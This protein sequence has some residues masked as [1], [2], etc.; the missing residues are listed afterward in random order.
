LTNSTL[1]PLTPGDWYLAVSNASSGPVAYSVKATE[2]TVTGLPIGFSNINFISN[3]LCLTW[4]SLVGA[5]YFVEGKPSLTGT[6]WTVISPS[7]LATTSS[8]SYCV[9]LPST[10]N[11]FRVQEGL[12]LTGNSLIVPAPVISATLVTNG[13]LLTWNGPA[14]AQ[15]KAQWATN[16]PNSWNFFSNILTSTNGQF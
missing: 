15:Y 14:A 6:N 9:A 10:N 16:L 7:M 11:F 1:V 5:Y 4:N 8:M 13:F 12:G 3:S 2:W